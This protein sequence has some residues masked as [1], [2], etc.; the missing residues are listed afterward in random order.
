MKRNKQI[1]I[2]DTI[3]AGGGFTAA[4]LLQRNNHANIISHILIKIRFIEL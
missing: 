2:Q 1:E 3:E 4:D